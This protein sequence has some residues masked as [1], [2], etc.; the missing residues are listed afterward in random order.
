[1][2][3]AT[4]GSTPAM[5]PSDACNSGMAKASRRWRPAESPPWLPPQ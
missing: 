4:A 3:T 5:P 1:M 2:R